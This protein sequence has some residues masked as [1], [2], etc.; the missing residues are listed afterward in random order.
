METNLFH[1][2]AVIDGNY[3]NINL[4]ALFPLIVIDCK[5]SSNLIFALK[6]CFLASRSTLG[7]KR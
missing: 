7:V 2:Q 5:S 6:L 4:D 1:M 3:R